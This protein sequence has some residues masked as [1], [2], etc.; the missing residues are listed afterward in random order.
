MFKF[1]KEK[2]KSAVNRITKKIEDKQEEQV[3]KIQDSKRKRC[4]R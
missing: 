1:L 4:G 2:L 3:T